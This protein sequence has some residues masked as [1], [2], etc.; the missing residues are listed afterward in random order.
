MLT[1]DSLASSLASSLVA[2]FRL[3]PLPPP[4][5]RPRPPPLPR[6]T[7]GLDEA[8]DED[9]PLPPTAPSTLAALAPPLA[10]PLP[11]LVVAA[12]GG[13]GAMFSLVT[14][15]FR[16]CSRAAS[17][18][19]VPS[20]LAET[21]FSI[22]AVEAEYWANGG[23]VVGE[24]LEV[25]GVV[26]CWYAPGAFGGGPLGGC[27]RGALGAEVDAAGCGCGDA[28]VTELSIAGGVAQGNS[29][30]LNWGFGAMESASMSV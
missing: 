23:A 22:S 19:W 18:P 4:R 15:L 21:R 26:S 5:P 24:P 10:P 12:A 13:G 8:A 9:A 25:L 1:S 14:M 11:R 30:T 17:H 7:A 20:A 29:A 6:P 3:P 28:V 27:E 16:T 2:R